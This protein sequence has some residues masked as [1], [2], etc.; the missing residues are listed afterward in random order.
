MPNVVI[1]QEGFTCANALEYLTT[2][3]DPC[4]KLMHKTKLLGFFQCG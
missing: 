2:G 1:H 3:W 4:T